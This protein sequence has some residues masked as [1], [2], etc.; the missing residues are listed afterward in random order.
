M[1]SQS[2]CCL[3]ISSDVLRHPDSF[4]VLGSLW[5]PN[6]KRIMTEDNQENA[7]LGHTT[8]SHRSS[9]L[10]AVCFCLLLPDTSLIRLLGRSCFCGWA[11]SGRALPTPSTQTT[12]CERPLPPHPQKGP[13]PA[14]MV[15]CWSLEI[16]TEFNE[17]PTDHV[18]GPVYTSAS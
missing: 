9:S 15:F 7:V 16:P 12:L 6:P 10:T 17:G 5:Y 3:S 11:S 8:N 13:A 1:P 4:L 18:A 14:L 2:Q